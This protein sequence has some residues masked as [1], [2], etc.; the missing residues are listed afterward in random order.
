LSLSTPEQRKKLCPIF[1]DEF[2][3][4]ND[5]EMRKFEQMCRKDREK[6]TR[7]YP[8]LLISEEYTNCIKE[9]FNRD[10]TLAFLHAKITTTNHVWTQR[11]WTI[12]STL[13]NNL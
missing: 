10:R 6:S 12:L 1:C 13:W 5:V 8:S 2:G 11:W 9:P 4:Q 3:Y 7:Q